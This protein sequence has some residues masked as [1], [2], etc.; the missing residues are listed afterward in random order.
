[1]L[2]FVV[3]GIPRS[4]KAGSRQTWQATVRRAAESALGEGSIE[5]GE[6]SAT[7]VHFFRD[8]KLDVDNMAKPILDAL[9]GTLIEDDVQVSQLVV[10]RTELSSGSILRGAPLAVMD[11]IQQGAD[12]V[13]VRL[14]DAPDH[15]VVP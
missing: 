9:K 11:G 14:G 5:S 1:M 13:Y 2:E 4:P 15:G 12:F 10:R 3:F 7:I 8:G 6:I